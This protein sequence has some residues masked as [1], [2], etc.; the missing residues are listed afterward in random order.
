MTSVPCPKVMPGND[1][2]LK[3]FLYIYI[4]SAF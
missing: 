3:L 1:F 4:N 2:P